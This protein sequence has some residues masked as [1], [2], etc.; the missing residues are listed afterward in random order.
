MHILFIIEQAPCC[1]ARLRSGCSRHNPCGQTLSECAYSKINRIVVENVR[2][3]R[4]VRQMSGLTKSALW[5][6][7][8]YPDPDS[9]GGP[10][11]VRYRP[12]LEGHFPMRGHHQD[13]QVGLPL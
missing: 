5:P 9:G 7:R 6:N 2:F 8:R 10:K 3:V 13:G 11:V 4:N 1:R 12:R